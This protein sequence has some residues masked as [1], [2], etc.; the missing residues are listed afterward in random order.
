MNSIPLYPQIN[1]TQ[2]YLDF[3]LKVL[4]LHLKLKQFAIYLVSE[5]ESDSRCIHDPELVTQFDNEYSNENCLKKQRL[6]N[7]IYTAFR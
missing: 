6:S 7:G 1:F 2:C 5:T 4:Q 3:W